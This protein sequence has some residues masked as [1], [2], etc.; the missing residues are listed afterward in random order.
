LDIISIFRLIEIQRLEIPK[1]KEIDVCIEKYNRLTDLP[2]E[3]FPILKSNIEEE[4]IID[5][6][7]FFSIVKR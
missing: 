3:K 2:K 1:A 6:I 7:L 4:T 5:I